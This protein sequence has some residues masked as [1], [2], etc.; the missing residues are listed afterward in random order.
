MFL[1]EGKVRHARGIR[2]ARW[3]SFSGGG[4][5]SPPGL[6]G[7]AAN[8]ADAMAATPGVPRGGL[9]PAASR[10]GTGPR[11]NLPAAGDAGAVP[12]K[13]LV[14]L[15]AGAAGCL[16]A[17]G[18]LMLGLFTANMTGN[19]ILLG[20]SIGREAWADALHNLLALAACVWGAGAGTVLT[21]GLRRVSHG[22]AL[23][24]VVLAAAMAVWGLFGAPR[25]RI[26]EPAVYWLIALLS[27]AMGIQ[28]A[29]VRRVGEQRVATTY[30][31]GTLTTLATDTAT[32]LFDRWS[33]RRT[34]RAALRGAAGARRE[35]PALAQSTQ[36]SRANALM[37]ALWAVYLLGALVGGFAEKHWSM[38]TVAAPIMVL[39]GVMAS[40][41]AHGRGEV[42]VR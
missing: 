9:R 3:P 12:R 6:A 29:T 36:T 13:R 42:A 8:T 2:R 25:G 21:R 1:L 18:Y 35:P 33:A 31:T 30:V 39:L 15:L 22:L 19:T 38:W 28:S 23:E 11:Q 24:A 34:A 17:V 32:E 20:L 27:A 37:A 10:A 41:V 26:A 40:D 16:D 7:T 5:C 14:L 4:K